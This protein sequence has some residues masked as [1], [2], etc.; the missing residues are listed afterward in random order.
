MISSFRSS[1]HLL[2]HFTQ[3]LSYITSADWNLMKKHLLNT[4]WNSNK[5]LTL[6]Y[7]SQKLCLIPL[8][9]VRFCSLSWTLRWWRRSGERWKLHDQNM[10]L[11]KQNSSTTI[12]LSYKCSTPSRFKTNN[13]I[14]RLKYLIYFCFVVYS[15][16]IVSYS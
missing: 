14:K 11:W 12:H 7:L 4:F 8:V 2:I 6:S 1:I 3:T 15:F 13:R 16:D 10:Q 5:S 9:L